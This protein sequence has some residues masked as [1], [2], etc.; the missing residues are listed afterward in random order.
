MDSLLRGLDVTGKSVLVRLDLDL[1]ETKKSFDTTRLED[2]LAT[3]RYL[4]DHKAKL[5]T[6]IGHR[7]RPE[8][9]KV[10]KLSLKP[11]ETLILKSLKAPKEIKI[12]VKENLRFDS[13]EEKGSVVFA[14][15]LAK[16]H[17]LFVNDAFASSHR[18]HTSI[19]YIP[20][21][22]PSCFGLQFE[23][24]LRGLKPVIESP[25][26]PFV[27]IF[28]GAKLETKL[29]MIQQIAEK[30]DIILVGGKLAL[31]L[32][33]HP[34]E[35]RKLIIGKLNAEGKD[36]SKPTEEQF[37]RF[38]A[39]AE[40]IVWNGPMGK[41]EDPKQKAGT[42]AIAHMIAHKRAYTVIGGGDTEAALSSMK[43]G[44]SFS[45]ISSGGGAMLE[46]IAKGTLPG[47]EAITAKK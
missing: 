44:G 14:R 43:V 5:I 6:V 2:G 1:P 19:T 17:D 18:N 15:E 22:L 29:P 28:G 40:T 23:K 30:A 39:M 27:M 13:R 33:G 46:Y 3:L 31:E 36:I 9:K 34:I 37:S 12:V 4:V 47:I 38:V 20:K 25:K 35:H 8:G 21:L 11:I 42:R 26:R 32:E 45:F 10:S 41:I 16:G 7:G 24:E